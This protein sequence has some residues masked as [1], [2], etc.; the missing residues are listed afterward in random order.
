MA[1]QNNLIEQLLGITKDRA[2]LRQLLQEFNDANVMPD[3]L[4]MHMRGD[5]N[6]TQA[7]G[8]WFQANSQLEDLSGYKNALSSGIAPYSRQSID[9]AIL[10]LPEM[11]SQ[12]EPYLIE[13]NITPTLANPLP[14]P[15]TKTPTQF[16]ITN[17]EKIEK[18]AKRASKTA[19]VP[20]ATAKPK[21]GLK[22]WF[23]K[24][25]TR[26][27]N[28]QPLFD[29]NGP[30]MQK[31][32]DTRKTILGARPW[33]GGPKVSTIANTLNAGIQGVQAAKGLYDNSQLD[34]DISSLK[35]DI[36]ELKLSNPMYANNLTPDQLK[37]LRQLDSGT[38]GADLGNAL[39]GG[40]KGIPNALFGALIGGLT[41]G[42]PGA[43]IGGM[44][45]L[46]NSG[47]SEYGKAQ[48]EQIAELQGLYDSLNRGYSDYRSMKR[49]SGLYTGGLQSAYRNR[50]N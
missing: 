11:K 1:T 49:P 34:T 48:Q 4:S 10:P 5:P 31:I 25:K 15:I 14:D 27:Q 41:G 40:I 23:T 36:R 28:G 22:N 32:K 43:L 24:A 20:T 8:K 44:G 39:E 30:S 29:M 9:N 2:E 26:V 6:A 38:Q 3:L 37:T 18:F 19:A 50:Y 45:S 47:I 21:N 17:P 16:N 42:V 7:L 12:L 33:N 13:N 35:Q 46:A